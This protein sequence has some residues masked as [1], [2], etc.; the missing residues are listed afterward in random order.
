MR[1]HRAPF[2]SLG[3]FPLRA[4]AQWHGLEPFAQII[5]GRHIFG[6]PLVGG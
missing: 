3:S 2:S 6:R 1:V 4:L 5:W